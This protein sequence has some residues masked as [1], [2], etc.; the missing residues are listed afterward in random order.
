M[1]QPGA[2]GGSPSTPSPTSGAAPATVAH[3][4]AQPAACSTEKFS[5]WPGR[6]V[7]QARPAVQLKNPVMFVVLIGTVI[8][9]VEAIA[10]PASSPGPSPSGFS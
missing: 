3:G 6:V 2:S 9:F 7:P 4:V 1:N 10:H 8:T 5:S